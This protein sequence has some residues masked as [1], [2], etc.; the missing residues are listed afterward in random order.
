MG[1]KCE[2]ACVKIWSVGDETLQVPGESQHLSGMLYIREKHES[3]K[4]KNSGVCCLRELRIVAGQPSLNG[5]ASA[6]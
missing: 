2:E 3:F 6:I 5:Q 1:K 4:Q